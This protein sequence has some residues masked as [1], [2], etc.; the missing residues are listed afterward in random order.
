MFGN[1]ICSLENNKIRKAK[2]NSAGY[3]ELIFGNTKVLKSL[4][5][6]LLEFD[7]PLLKRKWDKIDL[8]YM[9]QYEKAEERHK[10]IKEMLHKKCHYKEI[11]REVGISSTIISKIR[12]R[13]KGGGVNVS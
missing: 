2:I 12:K 1:K 13:L 7:L 8:G 3:V 6:K 10:K 5:R 4:K 9:S 11:M